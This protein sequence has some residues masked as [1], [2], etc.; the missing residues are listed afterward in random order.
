MDL[1]VGPCEGADHTHIY[2]YVLYA[3]VWLNG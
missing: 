1:G 3:Y 2:V